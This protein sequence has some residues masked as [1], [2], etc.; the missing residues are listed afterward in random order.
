ML[1]YFALCC[2]ASPADSGAVAS[3]I[4]A[5]M[6]VGPF[7]WNC[8]LRTSR[9][10]LFTRSSAAVPEIRI[11][12][13]AGVI[14][15]DLFPRR[16]DDVS[17]PAVAA[18]DLSATRRLLET[19]G[20]SVVS[21]YFGHYILFLVSSQ[22]SDSIRVVRDPTGYFPCYYAAVDGLTIIFSYL[23]DFIAFVQPRL[24][25]N[26]RF[27]TA[28][29]CDSEFK[30]SITGLEEVSELMPGGCLAIDSSGCPHSDLYWEP[31]QFVRL[32]D[33]RDSPVTPAN[34]R[35]R[36]QACVDS[37]TH[38]H[39]RILHRLSGGLDSSGIL[40]CLTQSRD[41][42]DVTC[43]HHTADNEGDERDYARLIAARRKTRL[44][45]HTAT[46]PAITH[47]TLSQLAVF[48]CP[49]PFL[50]D[51]RNSRFEQE[52]A[53]RELATVIID[54]AGGDHCFF[55]SPI[56]LAASDFLS[57]SSIN[58]ASFRL[59]CDLSRATH[60]SVWALL[61]DAI[62]NQ[63]C[64]SY[65][66]R[67]R[68][69]VPTSSLV[70]QEMWTAFKNDTALCHPWLDICGVSAAQ[71][72]QLLY[73]CVLSGSNVYYSAFRESD[74]PVAAVSPLSEQPIVELS[75]QIP[76]T[77]HCAHGWDRSVERAAFAGELPAEICMRRRKANIATSLSRVFMHNL[78]L[79]KE[80]LLDGA[81]VKHKLLRRDRLEAELYNSA[82]TNS[83]NIILHHYL[84]L[85][86]SVTQWS[87]LSSG[88]PARDSLPLSRDASKS[89]YIHSPN[90]DR[91][92]VLT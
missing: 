82:G 55:Q 22:I 64:E 2:N 31:A 75:L 59:L 63:R 7:E 43:V 51:L 21:E 56:S 47:H 26:W 34:V 87:R 39:N 42:G 89:Q 10:M 53:S 19:C 78:S 9:F 8:C 17:G 46:V 16:T 65:L 1:R 30:G 33:R 54:G 13:N 72:Q 29:A 85:E 84:S 18:L 70:D 27:I 81:L 4:C 3:R 66:G 37:F 74:H 86:V 77:E 24:S 91:P 14:L 58:F 92:C 83:Q 36:L 69:E 71:A 50:F 28:I 15:G 32:Q 20:R 60:R 80:V 23:E 11:G 48:P 5:R 38:G 45:E 57:R 44:I 12:A 6:P 35:R 52:V 62:K 73:A 79:L 25:V 68:A 67:H 49:R 40:C 90:G 61:K 88:L 76:V 41:A